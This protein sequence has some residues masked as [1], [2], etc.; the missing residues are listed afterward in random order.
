ME[1]LMDQYEAS[2]EV[3]HEAEQK[4]NERMQK[5]TENFVGTAASWIASTISCMNESDSSHLDQTKLMTET[6][7]A[8]MDSDGID[9]SLSNRPFHPVAEA[10]G[11][12]V[13]S[14]AFQCWRIG[15][16]VKTCP[17]CQV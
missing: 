4:R 5:R 10:W 16:N 14:I 7:S 9:G 12:A 1:T 8:N 6:N 11:A 17:G 15:A 13:D 2:V 3:M